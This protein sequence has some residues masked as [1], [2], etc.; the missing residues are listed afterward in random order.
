MGNVSRGLI[1]KLV[2]GAHEVKVIS[3]NAEKATEIEKLQAIPL[4]GSLEDASFVSDSFGDAHAVYTMV[5]PNFAVSD[6]YG[7]A[8]RVHENYAA[9]IRQHNIRH[10]VNLSSIGVALAGVGPL[11]RFYNLEKRL[12]DIPALNIVHLRPAMFYTNFYGSMGLAKQQGIVGHNFSATDDVLMTHPGDIADTAFTL[13]D[14]PSFNGHQIKYI[15]SDIQNGHAIAEILG[16][17]VGTPLHW[18]EFPD[19]VLLAGLVQNGFSLDAAETV[20]VDTGKAIR[21]GLFDEFK[22]YALKESRKFADFAKSLSQI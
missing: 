5:P 12:D 1:E 16:E 13:L 8:D 7:F 14:S 10:V 11:K 9:A 18:V 22:K 4:I 6:Y 19:D 2:A 3:T 17:A 21:A 20:I 15:I